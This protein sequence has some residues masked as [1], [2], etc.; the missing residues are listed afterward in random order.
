MQ[1]AGTLRMIADYMENGFL[2]N[3]VDMF[4]HD[5]GLYAHV[6]ALM[7]DER[8]RVRIGITALV[9]E[10]KALHSREINAL[11]PALAPLLKHNSPTIRADAAYLMEVIGSEDALPYLRGAEGDGSEAVRQVVREAIEA[12]EGGN[13]SGQAPFGV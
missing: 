7:A 3:I 6:P 13:E 9:D 12:I 8:S 11:V 1:D 10:L 2:E 4:K 5:R